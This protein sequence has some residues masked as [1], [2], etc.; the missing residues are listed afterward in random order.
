MQLYA[1]IWEFFPKM[2]DL[3]PLAYIEFSTTPATLAVV[4]CNHTKAEKTN[5]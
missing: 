5:V 3:K 2:I 1:Q 4:K